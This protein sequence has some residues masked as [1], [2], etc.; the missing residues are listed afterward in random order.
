MSR[1]EI[2]FVIIAVV[3]VL[4]IIL[5][6]AAHF[7][8][9]RNQRMAQEQREQEAREQQIKQEEWQAKQEAEEKIAKPIRIN[10]R[11]RIRAF[12]KEHPGE[13]FDEME[14]QTNI[15]VTTASEDYYFNDALQIAL[16]TDLAA[17]KGYRWTDKEIGYETRRRY[18]YYVDPDE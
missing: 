10:L 2:V 13:F 14:L 6:I 4:I 15:G 3:V 1:E 12:L 5:R 17:K 16:E 18:Y 9:Q 11:K 7:E 8:E